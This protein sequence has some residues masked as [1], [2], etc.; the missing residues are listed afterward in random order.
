LLLLL[1]LL[2]KSFATR[3]YLFIHL[4]IEVTFIISSVLN[5]I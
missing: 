2:L 3:D 1:L 4:I 5:H